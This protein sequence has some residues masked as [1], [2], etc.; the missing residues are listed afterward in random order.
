M[1]VSKLNRVRLFPDR[2]RNLLTVEQIDRLDFDEAMLP[3]DSWEGMLE[4]DEFQVKKIVDIWS[5]RKTR[6]GRIYRQ[7]KVYWIE[8]THS[9]WVD[10]A[11]LNCGARLQEFDRNRASHEVMQSQEEDV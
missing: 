8:Y 4:E 7:Y 6:Y 5:R 11:D 3:E 9:T 10:K 1:H 2:P